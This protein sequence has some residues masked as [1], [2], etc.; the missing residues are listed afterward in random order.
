MEEVPKTRQEAAEEVRAHLVALRG[1]APF[2]SPTDSQRLVEWLEGGVSVGDILTALELAAE[3]RRKKRS[4]VPLALRHAKPYIGKP[5]KGVF[6][7]VMRAPQPGIHPLKPMVDALVAAAS[8]D[9]RPI[10]LKTLAAELFILS[11]DDPEDLVRGGLKC[12]RTFFIDS[13][14]AL[15]E[16][17][18]TSRCADAQK[19]LLDDAVGTDDATMVRL[20]EELA[21]DRLRREYPM[22]SAGS[23]WDLVGTAQ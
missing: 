6:A 17:D 2:L 7:K 13:W 12:I 10:R 14:N 4:R 8:A 20:A 11:P 23:L 19:T 5:A 9:S 15:P 18:R 22:L 3:K 16:P 21:R 1:G